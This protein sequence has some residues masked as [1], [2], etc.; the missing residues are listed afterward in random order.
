MCLVSGLAVCLQLSPG[1]SINAQEDHPILTGGVG[2]I[3]AHVFLQGRELR[4]VSVC[5]ARQKFATVPGL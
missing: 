3:P 1:Q 2:G 4:V 5:F